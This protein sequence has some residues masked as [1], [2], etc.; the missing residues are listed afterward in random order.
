MLI[1]HKICDFDFEV[2]SRTY[3]YI[4]FPIELLEFNYR[5][6]TKFDWLFGIWCKAA[7]NGV[8]S[9][10]YLVRVYNTNGFKIKTMYD[11]YIAMKSMFLTCKKFLSPFIIYASFSFH[12][13]NTNNTKTIQNQKS[14]K[15]KNF[16]TP[17]YILTKRKL[18]KKLSKTYLSQ[19]SPNNQ[20]ETKSQGS[21]CD[22]KINHKE[23]ISHGS[24][25]DFIINH[26]ETI[27]HGAHDISQ[28]TI[29]IQLTPLNNYLSNCVITSSYTPSYIIPK[30][31][32]DSKDYVL[33]ITCSK[34]SSICH[35]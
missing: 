27:S 20:K 19:G 1:K 33:K 16:K 14:F 18:V 29:T 26:K 11:Y 28:Y 35:D 15:N 9:I 24:P 7:M 23:T 3:D 6:H 17:P 32:M 13:L 22:S 34:P 2:S 31:I 4:I 21:P 8:V 12:E 30:L 5:F 25:C 10:T